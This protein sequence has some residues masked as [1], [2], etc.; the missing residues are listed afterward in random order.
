MV[1]QLVRAGGFKGLV[2]LDGLAGLEMAERYRPSGIILDVG[3]PDM[4]GWS[5]MERLKMSRVTR[6]IPV[7]FITAG[8]GADRARRMGAVGFMS[9]PV[10]AEQIRGAIRAL[11]GAV[12][13][14][15]RERAHGRCRPR[16]PRRAVR[17]PPG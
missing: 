7:H 17:A 6:E 1:L 4:D 12:G 11:E 2:A 5:V 8:D 3:L 10:A 14:P 15:V 9:K 16:R 13:Q